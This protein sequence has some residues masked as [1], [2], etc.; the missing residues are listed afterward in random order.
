VNG[1]KQ[2]KQMQKLLEWTAKNQNEV[3]ED[4]GEMV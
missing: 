1:A 4:W 3:E 2:Q